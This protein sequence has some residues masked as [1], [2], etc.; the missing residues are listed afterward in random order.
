MA[1][2]QLELRKREHE[3]VVYLDMDGVCVD[4]VSAA[5]KVNDGDPIKV[6]AAWPEGAYDITQVM[7]IPP[8]QFWKKVSDAGV[9]FWR[10][11]NYYPWFWQMYY[12]LKEMADVVFL[13]SPSEDVWS[14]A[15]K[16]GWLQDRFGKAFRNYCLT[17]LKDLGANPRAILI[18]DFEVHVDAFR[19][20]GGR[21]ILFPQDWNS[22]PI[23]EDVAEYITDAVA[24]TIRTTGLSS[25]IKVSLLQASKMCGVC[26]KGEAPIFLGTEKDGKF[27]HESSGIV[28]EAQ[29]VWAKVLDRAI[30]TV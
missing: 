22:E 27:V 16:L 5:I 10:G 12:K 19:K 8:D 2:R 23:P 9:D 15:G 24:D 26:S 14:A 13:S 21:A 18:D 25:Y 7:E 28:C 30:D 20:A 29:H 3:Y 1:D 17:Q 6:L 11:L 4:F